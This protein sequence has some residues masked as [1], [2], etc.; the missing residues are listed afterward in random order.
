MSRPKKQEHE[1]LTPLTFS[2]SPEE[3][4]CVY[5][6]ARL[7]RMTVSRYLRHRCLLA[8]ILQVK[9]NPEQ[10]HTVT[11]GDSSHAATK[12]SR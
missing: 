6:M 8:G 12:P 1:K 2:V 10:V 5:H 9:N 11:L 3:A 4:R 7:T